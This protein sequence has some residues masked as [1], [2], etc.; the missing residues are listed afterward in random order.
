[1][2]HFPKNRHQKKRYD[3]PRLELH[4]HVE[5]LETRQLLSVTDVGHSSENVMDHQAENMSDQIAVT[6]LVSHSSI[7]QL[8]SPTRSIP[9][10][11]TSLLPDA[12]PAD[13]FILGGSAS[14]TAALSVQVNDN[15]TLPFDNY[16]RLE[17]PT[18]PTNVWDINLSLTPL[19]D[20]VQDDVVFISF[21][22]RG[23][24]SGGATAVQAN[25]YLQENGT[26]SKLVTIPVNGHTQ[27][28][29]FSTKLE[30]G[31]SIDDGGYKFVIHAGFAEQ[32][33]EIGGLEIQNY[34]RLGHRLS[35]YTVTVQDKFGNPLPEATLDVQMTNHGFKFG[36]QVR[37]QLYAIT[38]EEFNALNDSQRMALTPNLEDSFNI[39][40]FVPTW[41]D[42]LNH[43]NAVLNTFNHVVPTT[44]FQWV[45]I[46]NSGTSVPE[47][48]VNR[49]TAD[50]QSVT[51]ASVVWQ[52]DRWP[53]PEA[54]RS[55][56][57]PNAQTFHDALV[58]ARLGPE[59]VLKK[60]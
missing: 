56:S 55:A 19:G 48:A 44:G 6:R 58:D 39:S 54:Y 52:K 1:M 4:V 14:N 5:F 49:A 47:A 9:A 25:A 57:S 45:A 16:V 33:L 22:A 31:S 13:N 2:N 42:V 26:N 37:D 24:P 18:V 51:A 53:T 38:E 36:T 30:V 60:I 43:R 21:Y 27:W 46:E 40:R 12:Q 3:N 17:T 20:L 28:Q 8:S 23:E 11:G 50:G 15:Q 7:S 29:H 41:T 35:D 34:G 32:A 10:G 59:S